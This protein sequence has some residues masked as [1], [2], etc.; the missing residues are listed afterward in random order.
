MQKYLDTLNENDFEVFKEIESLR[1]KIILEDTSI[2]VIDYGAGNPDENRTEKQ[3]HSGV[4][5]SIS[6]KSLCKIG[7]KNNFAHLIYAIVKKHQP[8]TVLELGTCCGFSSIEGSP[9][10]AQI[11]QRNFKEIGAQNIK[12]YVGRFSDKLP[13]ILPKITPIEFAFID[14]HHDRDATLEYFEN[15]K[16]YLTKDALVLFDDISW[17]NGMIEAWDIIKKDNSI[18]TYEDYVKVGLCFM[19]DK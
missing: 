5:K 12:S 10:T 6:T 4:T 13:N 11:A 7:L 3:M 18:H 14:G 9:Q 8:A 15:I 17:S 19:G 16:P 2:E 1:E